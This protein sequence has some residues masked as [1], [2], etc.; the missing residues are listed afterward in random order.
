MLHENPLMADIDVDHW[1]N[2]QHLLLDSAK[3]KRRIIVIHEGGTIRKFVHSDRRSI[4]RPV[5][6]ITAPADDAEAIYRANA[7]EVDFVAVFERNAFDEYFARCQDSWRSDEDLDVFVHR[8]YAL[9]D[10]YPNGIVTYPGPARATLGLQWRVGASYAA[11]TDAVRTLVPPNS[12]VVFGIVE[13]ENLWATL[14]LGF[15]ADQRAKVVTTADPSQLATTR[16]DLPTLAAEVV[17]WVEATFPPCSIGLFSDVAGAR[18]FLAAADKLTVITGLE[19][20]GRLVLDP[21]P[22]PLRSVVRP[23]RGGTHVG[24][25]A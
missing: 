1:R 11:V 16:G 25:G 21:A 3:E 20:A 15:D 24:P 5:E 14:V 10:E 4:V 17:R 13:G 9:M 2:L 23:E 22:E 6:Q 7:D 12:S 19:A 8:T 18:A